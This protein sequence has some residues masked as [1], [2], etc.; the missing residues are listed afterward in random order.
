[1]QA[2]RDLYQSGTRRVTG[3]FQKCHE[4][5]FGVQTLDPRNFPG[6]ECLHIKVFF[7]A[8]KLGGQIGVGHITMGSFEVLPL[9]SYHG[10]GGVYVE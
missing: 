3:G 1:M 9:R 4:V 2:S 6:D 7:G 5:G 10:I 8:V